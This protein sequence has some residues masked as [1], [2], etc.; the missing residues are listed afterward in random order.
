LAGQ[1]LARTGRTS[2][3]LSLFREGIETA[4]ANSLRSDLLTLYHL[5]LGNTL[6]RS[7]QSE[8]ALTELERAHASW[9]LPVAAINVD[10]IGRIHQEFENAGEQLLAAGRIA[11][12]LPQFRALR[13][14]AP[15][16]RKSVQRW[17]KIAESIL[18]ASDMATASEFF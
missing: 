11:E 16:T 12:S 17:T 7:G 2:E 8:E 4:K 15:P 5:R 3:A 9:Q 14:H 1:V 18:Q 10:L 6:L 13:E